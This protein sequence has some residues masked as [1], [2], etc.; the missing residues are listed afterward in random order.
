VVLFSFLLSSLVTLIFKDLN[1][2]IVAR[3]AYLLLVS[4]LFYYWGEKI[5]TIL[6]ISVIVANYF[7]GIWLD[8][9]E[10]R[11][12]M[13]LVIAVVFNLLPLTF[14]KYTNFFMDN[15]NGV[16]AFLGFTP[17]KVDPIHL[18]IGISFFTFQIMSYIIDLYWK[19]AEVQKNPVSLGLYI[20]LFPQLIAGPIVRYLDIARQLAERRITLD[21][22]AYGVR[23]FIV[24]LGKKVLIANVAAAATDRIY[25]IPGEL[26]PFHVAW[27][28]ATCYIIQLYFDFS[29]YSDMAIGLGRMFGFKI[30]EN[31]NYPYIA[32]SFR[33]FWQRWH[34][35]LTTWFR[36]YVYFPLGGSKVSKRRA[37]FNLIFVF[38]LT[39]F[40]H[41]ASWNFIIWG[42]FHGV[43]LL[44]ERVTNRFTEKLWKPAAH[45]LFMLIFIPHLVIFRA[46]TIPAAGSF[47]KAM[48]GFTDPSPNYTF[49]L[50]MN[51]ELIV[52]LILGVIG[53]TPIVPFIN[54]KLE[55][56]LSKREGISQNV[57]GSVFSTV[58]LISMAAIMILSSMS[59][60]SDTYNPF[61]YFRF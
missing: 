60:A 45:V 22:F 21:D 39:G 46:E 52:A 29:G 17:V 47:Y 53:S 58:M 42:L 28:G 5:F 55:G 20:A 34:I 49:S 4:L 25:A 23:R 54:N 48:F 51:N 43:V 35:S 61:I 32:R 50:F 6:M 1:K 24:G 33:L 13:V 19:K 2:R 40:W 3:N 44:V 27:L 8:R 41:G 16:I 37:Y 14:F 10:K 31:F 36:D 56:F 15:I 30:P 57:Y 12:K 11:R 18:P 59:L 9:E 7:L 26:L 38:V